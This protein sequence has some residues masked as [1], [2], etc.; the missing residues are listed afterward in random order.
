MDK[1]FFSVREAALYSGLSVR[2]IYQKLTDRVLRHYRVNSKIVIDRK[3]LDGMVMQNEVR[4]IEE[5]RKQLEEKRRWAGSWPYGI[6]CGGVN[7][8]TLNNAVFFVV[9]YNLK[10]DEGM[11][12]DKK[13]WEEKILWL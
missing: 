8:G 10:I 4:T 1:R 7:S 3:D 13:K 9:G 2:L 12:I 5:L 11:N 6:L